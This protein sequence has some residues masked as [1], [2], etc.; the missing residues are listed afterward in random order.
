M[1]GNGLPDHL[2]YMLK[3]ATETYGFVDGFGKDE[4]LADKRTQQAVVMSLIINGEAATKVMDRY[5]AFVTRHSEIPW[6]GMRNRIAPRLL[7]H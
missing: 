3:A 7:R 5:G 1:S 2:D 4:F 6:R